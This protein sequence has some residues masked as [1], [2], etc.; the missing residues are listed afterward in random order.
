MNKH[1]ATPI[2]SK[3][4]ETAAGGGGIS[5]CGDG[6]TSVPG[7]VTARGDRERGGGGT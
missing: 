7:L 1:I 6:G 3:R 2:T 4:K 5:A